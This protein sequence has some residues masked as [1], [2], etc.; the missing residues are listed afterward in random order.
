MSWENGK[1]MVFDDT[2][3]HS[4]HNESDQ[5]RV[6]LLLDFSSGVPIERE[7]NDDDDSEEEE[8]IDQ[9]GYLDRIT[10]AYGYGVP[11]TEEK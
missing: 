5:E 11:D 4:A 2:Y 3:I 9:T 6:I 7:P 10:T 8:V 1:C